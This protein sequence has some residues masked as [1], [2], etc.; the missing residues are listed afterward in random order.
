MVFFIHHYLKL[1]NKYSDLEILETC[2]KLDTN[3]FEIKQHGLNLRA[4]YRIACI[5]SHD[6][7][8]NTRHTFNPDNSINLYSTVNIGES[9]NVI[10]CIVTIFSASHLSIYVV[11]FAIFVP[12]KGSKITASYTQPLWSTMKRREHLQMS[13][14]FWCKCQRCQDPTE[15]ESGLSTVTCNECGGNS[16]PIN[17]LDPKTSW[18]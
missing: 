1:I 15:L 5:I 4:M 13:K 17:P 2:G 9:E 18:A 16:L 6:C 14:C 10:L 11:P 7:K 12:A 8:P 3:C